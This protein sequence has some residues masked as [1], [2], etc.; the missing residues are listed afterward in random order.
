MTYLPKRLRMPITNKLHEQ[1]MALTL[2]C[3]DWMLIHVLRE[4]REKTWP[5]S[6]GLLLRP[7]QFALGVTARNVKL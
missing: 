1:M 6:E 5:P 2:Q 3:E 4:W 7:V